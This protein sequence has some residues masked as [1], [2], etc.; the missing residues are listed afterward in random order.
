MSDDFRML[1]SWILDIGNIFLY[2]L[3][4]Y[5]FIKKISADKKEASRAIEQN[6]KSK[7]CC[8]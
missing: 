4:V 6:R 1:Y 3:F 5:G 7:K 2:T 8:T